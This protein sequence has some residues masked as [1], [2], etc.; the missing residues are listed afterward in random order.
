M[1]S[2]GPLDQNMMGGPR[3][4]YS[5]CGHGS[6]APSLLS[7]PLWLSSSQNLAPRKYTNGEAFTILPFIYL[8]ICFKF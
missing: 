3:I 7:S 2:G 1:F 6:C 8:F 5:S 4:G